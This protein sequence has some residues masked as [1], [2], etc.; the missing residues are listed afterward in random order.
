MS[1]QSGGHRV[2]LSK[3]NE[4]LTCRLCGGYFIDATTII[5]CLHSFCRSCIVKYLENNKYCPICEVQVHKSKPLLNIRPDHTLQDIVYKL[6]PGCY[7]NEMRCRREFYAKHPDIRNQVTS[8]EARGEPIES[9]IY[10][11]DES[12]S[13]SLEYFNPHT[14]D[15]SETNTT[16]DTTEKPLLKRYLRCPAAVTVFHLQKLIRAKYG[17][18]DAHRVDIMYKEEP[19]C[20]SYTLMDVMYIYHWRRKVP[21][22]LSYRIF[23]SSSKR[24]KLSED[25]VNYKKSLTN[26]GIHSD[27]TKDEKSLKREWKEVQL[28][29]SETGVMSITDISNTVLKRE[30]GMENVQD[31]KITDESVTTIATVSKAD[32]LV[33]NCGVPKSCIDAMQPVVVI[34]AQITKNTILP[35][36]SDTPPMVTSDVKPTDENSSIKNCTSPP[37]QHNG[38]TTTRQT[39]EAGSRAAPANSQQD[40][41]EVKVHNQTNSAEDKPISQGQEVTGQVVTQCIEESA[42]APVVENTTGMDTRAKKLAINNNNNSTDLRAE[43]QKECVK[44]EVKIGNVGSKIDALSA[45]L[46][47]QPKI[48]QVNNTYSKK[49]PKEKRAILQNAKKSELKSPTES[50]K[51]ADVKT[52]TNCGSAAAKVTISCSTAASSPQKPIVSTATASPNTSTV[53]STAE[54]IKAEVSYEKDNQSAGIDVQQALNLLEQKR[55]SP[56]QTQAELVSKASHVSAA[57]G[58]RLQQCVRNSSTLA[59]IESAST[60]AN[61]S[62]STS[63]SQV[64]ST[65][66]YTVHDLV[67]NANLK[68][69]LKNSN[70]SSVPQNSL[71]APSVACPTS[72]NQMS[73]MPQFT[74][75]TPSMSIYSIPTSLKNN[76]SSASQAAA[77]VT[78]T[79]TAPIVSTATAKSTS[80]PTP[81]STPC[82]DAIPISL[83]KPSMRK[84][85][86]TAKGSN[87][88]E[89]C[90]KI[91]SNTTGSKINDICAKIGEN[92]KEKN[93]VEARNKSDIPDL[94]KIAKKTP[95]LSNSDTAIKHI[96]NIPNVPVYTPSSNTT[97]VESKGAKIASSTSVALAVPTSSAP[98]PTP[99]VSQRTSSLKKQNQAVG[100][101]TLRDPPKCWNPT[102]SKNNYVAVKNQ[103]QASA[104]EGTSKQIPS[105]PA[106]IFKMRNMPRYLGNPASGVKPMYGMTNDTK[107]KEQSTTNT[108]STTLNMMKIDPKT[109][110]PIVSTVNSPIVSPPPYSP[111]ARSYQNTPFARDM[112]RSS[113]SPISPRNSPVNMLSTNPFIPSPTPN[114]NP[115]IIYSHF[116][117]PFPD[118]SRFPNPLIRSP[119]GIPPPSAFHSSLPPSINK[120]YQRSSYIPQTT[121]YSP[122]A[123]Q[124][125]AVQRIPPSTHSSSPKTSS[126]NSISS[127]SF[128]M[129]KTEPITSTVNSVAL[130]LSKSVPVPVPVPVPMSVA[131][132]VSVPSQR[133]LN[134]FN[135]SKT[136]SL[137]VTS[138][139]VKTNTDD[140]HETR[141]AKQNSSSASIAP[142]P[143]VTNVE[144]SENSSPP[145]GSERKQCKDTDIQTQESARSREEVGQAS[146]PKVAENMSPTDKKEKN[147][148]TK[149]NGDVT[150]EH[151]GSKKSKEY[152]N[153]ETTV[154][155]TTTTTT[156]TTTTTMVA[157]AA[158]T[159]VATTP[160]QETTE[161]ENQAERSSPRERNNIHKSN[162]QA[163]VNDSSTNDSKT[164]DL[165]K[166]SEQIQGKKSEAQRNKAET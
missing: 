147:Q 101:K 125:P 143:A 34:D 160:I 157:T 110:S 61:T 27:E 53:D 55:N 137:T 41:R 128:N 28:K 81:T 8:P 111:N 132:P 126:P 107:E 85:E 144:V 31:Q 104:S 120:L 112:C 2:C 43:V 94:L 14:E 21:L 25:N 11:P 65:F 72:N 149:V 96:P 99:H 71:T 116:P 148:T 114:T 78:I 87:L 64:T 77:A 69:T 123:G 82:P 115:R 136:G 140:P 102:L 54:S 145:S 52:R 142:N 103:N 75:Q 88:N 19:L 29:I 20:S 97:T 26:A 151:F 93:R 74:M 44:S 7:Q 91:G 39:N 84:Q 86:A 155:T 153:D 98:T 109:L 67:T 24:M 139:T 161:R 50:V 158:T 119:I 30:S 38:S 134:A 83:M 56:T 23:E 6:V 100:Y 10:S 46:L 15:L 133:E 152:N 159:T 22:H 3:L 90:A 45:K 138:N 95:S 9:H 40:T 131:M 37:I 32:T 165:G 122:V 73:S 1:G 105:K 12:L 33:E 92:S 76:C 121:G 154:T 163:A 16:K 79:P 117:P 58:Q 124:P 42:P 135:L 66:P 62:T 118:A 5:E 130:L 129:G 89:I 4:Q 108:K 36:S 49:S 35:D 146:K 113:G 141:S 106:K 59:P 162:S 80:A 156:A 18:S 63:M 51:V 166:T 57:A 70:S 68:S 47:F 60:A 164:E 17:L 13:L 150:T 127:T 48:G